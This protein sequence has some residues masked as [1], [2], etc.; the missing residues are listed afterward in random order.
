MKSIKLILFLAWRNVL[1]YRRRTLQTFLILFCGTLSILVVDAFMKG[2][3]ANSAERIISL[4]GHLDVHA[5]GYLHSAEAMPLDLA[6]QDID[7][8][9]DAMLAAARQSAT[10]G[11]IPLTA[12]SAITGCMLSDGDRSRGA[13]VLAVEPFARS[14]PRGTVARNPFLSGAILAAGRYFVSPGDEGA[15]LDESYARKLNL[16]TGDSLI[17]LGNDATGSFSMMETPII[18]ITREATLPG[19]AGCAVD[20]LSFSRAFGLEGS[21]SAI[22]LWFASSSDL[23][24]AASDAEAA[25][26]RAVMGEIRSRPGLEVR[27]FTEISKSFAAMFDF[28]DT[29]LAG[30]MAIFALVASAGITNAILLSVQER[31][32]DLGTLRAI[33]LTSRQAG[34]LIYAETMI[35]GIAASLCALGVGTLVIAILHTT[36]TG[37]RFELT[38]IGAALPDS[39]RPGLFPSRLA[40]IA[41]ISAIFPVAAAMLPSRKVRKLTIRESLGC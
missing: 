27:P 9:M 26:V 33:A 12:A 23:E 6:I 35:T 17:L 31:V 20:L 34:L 25:A 30:M 24:L 41:L 13:P 39:I 36:G 3:A 2:Y 7:A 10:P 8:V 5:E 18:G 1:R 4:S 11:I 28:L 29:F 16:K 40:A 38:D 22:S 14:L 32:K 15:L 37:L 21:A 19:E